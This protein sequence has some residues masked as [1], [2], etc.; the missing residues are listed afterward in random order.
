[1]PSKRK[2]PEGIELFEALLDTEDQ[3]DDAVRGTVFRVCFLAHLFVQVVKK[4]LGIL[5]VHTI[6]ELNLGLALECRRV[7]HI[8]QGRCLAYSWRSTYIQR[9]ALFHFSIF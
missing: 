8:V 5:V 7:Q 9:P 1:M 2:E 3:G 4:L 6:V